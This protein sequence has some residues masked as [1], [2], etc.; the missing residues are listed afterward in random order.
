MANQEKSAAEL[1]REE[2]KERLAKAAKKNAKKSHNVVLTKKSK[3][4]I[5][6][7]LVLALVAGIV[8]FSINNSGVLERGK[9]AFTVGDTEVSMAE[10][11]YY[12][13]SAFSNY[14]NYSYQYDYYYG[15]G[16]G[17]MYTGYDYS[18][19]PDQQA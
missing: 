12:Y 7:V 18:V 4:A 5:A 14:F 16:M 11:S 6:V 8:A 2:R 17:A 19:S 3:T 1:Y 13:N 10:Y 9:V 15:E